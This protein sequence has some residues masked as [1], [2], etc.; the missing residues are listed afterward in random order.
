MKSEESDSQYIRI[1][2]SSFSFSTPFAIPL[3]NVPKVLSFQGKALLLHA[4]S[5]ESRFAEITQLV[6]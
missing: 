6:E 5:E 4:L 1:L 3:K 2:H